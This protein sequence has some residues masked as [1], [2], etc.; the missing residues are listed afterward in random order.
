MFSAIQIDYIKS[1]VSDM[2]ANGYLYY[3]AY[4]NSLT[5]NNYDYDIIIY[6]SKKEIFAP[7][8]Y[9]YTIP[10]N[11]LKY[12]IRSGNASTYNSEDR[13]TVSEVELG[14]VSLKVPAYSHVST[15]ATFTS[16][17]IQPNLCLEVKEYET[18]GSINFIFSV[19]IFV[20]CFIHL[21]R[22]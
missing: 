14:E 6:F 22:R 19:F 10:S 5:S 1:L 18:L 7:D 4:Q 12:S 3:L 13:V 17:F 11:S 16:S 9:E 2:R 21:F 15:N 20:F 8:L